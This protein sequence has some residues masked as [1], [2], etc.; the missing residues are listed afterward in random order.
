MNNILLIGAQSEL[1]EYLYLKKVKIKAVAD[2]YKFGLKFHEFTI[3]SVEEAVKNFPDL[4]IVICVHHGSKIKKQLQELGATKIFSFNEY[5]F[6]HEELLPYFSLLRKNDFKKVYDKNL[7]YIK[8]V[9]QLF[10]DKN[11]SIFIVAYLSGFLMCRD[12]F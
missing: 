9:E 8:K 10:F 11:Q 3:L 5:C 2:N 6:N 1:A 12:I 4:S 7:N